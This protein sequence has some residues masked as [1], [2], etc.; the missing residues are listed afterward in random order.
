MFFLLGWQNKFQTMPSKPGIVE[1][2][3][4]DGA[5][6]LLQSTKYSEPW[7]HGVGNNTITD[8]DATKTSSAEYLNVTVTSAAMLSQANDENTGKE[9]QHLKYIP[10]STSPSVGER[11]DPNSQMELVG[12]SIVLT[13]YPFSDAQC[14]QMLTSYGPQTTLPHFYGLHH[15]RMPLP[16]E[17]EA[18]PVYVNAKQYHGILRRRQSRAKAELEKKVIR[19][20]KPYLHESRHLHAMRR[21]R[22]SGG[23]F[24]N[25]KK[26]NSVISNKT[27]EEDINSGINHVSEPV[28][29]GGSNYMVA[30]ENGMKDTLDDQQKEDKE[31]MPQ[32]MQI[33]H[34][35]FNG[36]KSNG[37][38]LST[39]N[40]K[41]ADESMQVNAAPQRAIPIK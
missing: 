4:A 2:E 25:T 32:N 26:P 11:L 7:W 23:R 5:K 13:S 9:V 29:E 8:E 40:S 24:L 28:S 37:L 35:F 22:G 10:F 21:A 15:A 34:A 30:N 31:F 27:M 39:Y 36:G 18:E 38:G 1:Q 12:H 3:V 20:R 41:L 16:L 14:C 6:Y 19:S 17:M 33:T